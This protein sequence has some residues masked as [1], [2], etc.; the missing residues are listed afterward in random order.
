MTIATKN[1]AQLFDEIAGLEKPIDCALLYG[2]FG[3]RVFPVH[4]AREGR[5]TCGDAAC[6]SPAK[7]PLTKHGYRDATCDPEGIRD[8]FKRHPWAN[9]AIATEQSR[10]V[11]LDVDPKNGGVESL[12]RLKAE[13]GKEAFDS[14]TA[15]T[16]GGG[17]HTYYEANST[18]IK[19]V[20]NA[21]GDELPGLD[22]R[23]KGGYAVAPL[24]IHISGRPYVWLPR[25]NGAATHIITVPKRLVARLNARERTRGSFAIPN[26]RRNDTLFRKASLL[27]A[28]GAD[29]QEILSTVIRQ[30]GGCE[31]PLDLSE[32]EAIAHSAAQYR[33][34]SS[35]DDHHLLDELNKKIAILECP[36]GAFLYETVDERGYPSVELPRRRQLSDLYANNRRPNGF[37]N[38]INYWYKHP[39]R[40]QFRRIVFDPSGQAPKD[41]YNLWC[42]WPIEPVKGDCSK[43]WDHLRN[44]ICSGD[45]DKYQWLRR[46]MAHAIQRPNNLPE[47]AIILTGVEGAGK[48]VFVQT[49]GQLFGPHFISVHR[50]DD[51]V[52]RFNAHLAHVLLL[53]ADEATWGGDKQRQGVLKAGITEKRIR[54]EQKNQPSYEVN[55]YRRTIFASNEP[56]PVAVGENDR[57]F[58]L[59][60]VS[61]A[62]VGDHR[63]FDEIAAEMN[64]SGLQALMYDLINEDLQGWNPRL[65]PR[66]ATTWTIK[67]RGLDGEL[68][69]WYEILLEGRTMLED[70]PTGPDGALPKD[71]LYL[72]YAEF[73]KRHQLRPTDKTIFFR[74]AYKHKF[75]IPKDIREGNARVQVAAAALSSA[76]QAFERAVKESSEIWTDNELTIL[77]QAT[78]EF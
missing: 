48:G 21:F 38:V 53:Y 25:P 14:A 65:R 31:Q 36:P 3:L 9:V 40:R 71:G 5:C 45:E 72:G 28:K 41:C 50:T 68:R 16:G 30:N 75:L 64:H 10:L 13:I 63:Y 76:R 62:R 69:W 19:S 2:R 11:I 74:N 24:S 1:W 52:G 46:Y 54:V 37:G 77:P 73:C 56:W 55:N 43:F 8:L 35:L 6:K 59:L 57:R 78:I 58:V 22:T 39:Q 70:W 32:L 20:A 61:D 60:E 15:R 42:G 66:S 23:A 34:G 49:F 4:S 29:E 26:G 12:A 18:L 47:V 7:H 67:L 33:A 27:R 17:S 44:V 51:V